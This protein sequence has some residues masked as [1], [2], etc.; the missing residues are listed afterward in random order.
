MI[1]IAIRWLIAFVLLAATYNPTPYNWVRWSLTNYTEQL[2]LIVLSGL[3]LLIGY[4]QS[5][6][7][8]DF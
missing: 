5:P 3:I 6:R 1:R 2:P 7:A 8:P 4:T